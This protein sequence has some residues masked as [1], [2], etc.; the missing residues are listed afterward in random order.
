MPA[1]IPYTIDSTV[2]PAIQVS[3]GQAVAY[4]NANTTTSW[5]PRT[6]ET[7][8]LTFSYTNIQGYC[9]AEVGYHGGQQFTYLNDFCQT[10]DVLHEMG[11]IL[12]YGTNKREAIA[13][14]ISL[15]IARTLWIAT[16]RPAPVPHFGRSVSDL[17]LG[18]I[19]LDY[20]PYDYASIMH[21]SSYIDSNGQPT[22]LR[23][24]NGQPIGQNL[25]L[26]REMLPYLPTTT[27]RT[28]PR[29][30]PRRGSRVRRLIESGESLLDRYE[31]E[32]GGL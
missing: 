8:Y 13:I 14:A 17:G 32:Y 15:S 31:L 11:H 9:E 18:P 2:T 3:I 10:H 29:L 6:T 20:G 19:G 26:T 27:L 30:K 4:Y 28:H 21:Y 12:A 23:K 22:M 24:D 5:I 16:R 25:V 1:S 7:D